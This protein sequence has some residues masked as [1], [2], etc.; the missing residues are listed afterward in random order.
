MVPRRSDTRRAIQRVHLEAGIVGHDP[1]IPS[2][3][4]I[5]ERLGFDP[6]VAGIGVG[7]FVGIQR[8]A[9]SL[10]RDQ[11]D[12]GRAKLAEDLPKF[13]QLVRVVGRNQNG[14]IP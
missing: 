6:R 12:I 14:N 10:R 5:M 4:E 2:A 11:L 8:Q 7:G 1:E 3:D 9:K 13:L